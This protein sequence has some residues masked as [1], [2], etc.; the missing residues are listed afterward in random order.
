VRAMVLDID[1]DA[2]MVVSR[3]SEVSGHGFSLRKEYR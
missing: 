1:P 3:V 2:F